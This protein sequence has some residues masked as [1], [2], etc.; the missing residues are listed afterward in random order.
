M[1]ERAAFIRSPGQRVGDR[2]TTKP[3]ALKARFICA[4][5][6]LNGFESRFQRSLITSVEVPGA[7]PQALVIARIALH[8][9]PQN[10]KSQSRRSSVTWELAI[11]ICLGL[12]NWDLEFLRL[13]LAHA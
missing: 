10:S 7:L 3:P 6:R 1:R 9:L 4:V 13:C 12:G 11:G 8:P 2:R 5:F